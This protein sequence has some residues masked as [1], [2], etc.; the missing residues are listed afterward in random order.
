M[1]QPD[2]SYMFYVYSIM[3]DHDT[4]RDVFAIIYHHSI[5]KLNP[6]QQN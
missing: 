4:S 5:E 6:T 3:I 1:M 2:L